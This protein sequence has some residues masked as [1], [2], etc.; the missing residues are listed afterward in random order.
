MNAVVSQRR[1]DSPRRWRGCESIAEIC[2]RYSRVSCKALNAASA[3]CPSQGCLRP[4]I[5]IHD[6][7]AMTEET[8][9]KRSCTHKQD[10]A[11]LSCP[12]EE[13]EPHRRACET[14]RRGVS[15]VTHHAQS[16]DCSAM[17]AREWTHQDQSRACGGRGQGDEDES[18]ASLR[19]LPSCLWSPRGTKTEARRVSLTACPHE[20]ASTHFVV[21]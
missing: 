11:V 18:R 21:R 17:Q 20:S 14:N 5:P 8:R 15:T 10:G 9:R 6:L 19:V 4:C 3:Q 2:Q 12:I 13:E 1:V 7:S 16:A